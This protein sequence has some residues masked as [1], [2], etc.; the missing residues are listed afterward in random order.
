MNFWAGAGSLALLAVVLVFAIVRPRGWPEA[1]A[2]VPAA[3][4]ALLLGLVRPEAAGQRAVEILPTLGFLAAILLLSFLAS[5]DGVFS[6]LGN[7][8]AEACHGK[9]RRLLVLTF[10]AAAGVTAILSLDATVVLLTPVVLA[11]AKSL[12]L[13]PRPHVYACA[14]LANSA[15]TLLPVSNLTNLLAFAASGLTF[16]GFTALMALPWLVTIGIELLVFLR[17]FATDLRPRETAEPKQH[18]ETPTFALVILGLT[19]VGFGVGQLGHVEPVWIAALASLILG[20]RALA[21]GKI[22]PWQL[23]TEASP[24]LCLF[25]L[26]LAVVVEAVSEHVL[27]GLLGDVLPTSTGLLDLLIAAGVAAL[28]ANLVNNLPATLIL[29]S[30]LGPHPAPG[31]LLAVLLGVNIGPNATYL[32]SLATLLWRRTLPAPPSARTFH[33]LGA[34]TTPLCLAAATGA[35]WLSLSLAG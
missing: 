29:L 7:R 8:L 11:T 1:V 6:W 30:V 21:A 32:G 12:E 15:S 18:L 25:V 23:V 4:L 9:P 24:Q 33:A 19:L 28:L 27:G 3:G 34:L 31:V 22:R 16:A 13:P 10:A 35:L 17:F 26:G 5:V 2:A 20:V 14:H